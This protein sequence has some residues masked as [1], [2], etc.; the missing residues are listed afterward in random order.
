MRNL[1][2][3]AIILCFFDCAGD[4]SSAVPQPSSTCPQNTALLAVYDGLLATLC[5]CS[6][7]SPVYSPPGTR[8]LCTVPTGTLVLFQY[9][10]SQEKHQI[11]S[12][13]PLSFPPSPLSDPSDQTTM[14]RAH[15]VR[16]STP[17]TYSFQDTIN[18]SLAGDLIAI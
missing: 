6:Q 17:G 4:N 14:I 12:T 9:L 13:S 15:A 10:Q 3:I 5:G 2:A 11:M 1:L 8:L 16:L 7:A 18:T